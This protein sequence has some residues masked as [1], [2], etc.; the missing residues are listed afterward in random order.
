MSTL[1]L[2]SCFHQERPKSVRCSNC[3]GE[4][5][6]QCKIEELV[7]GNMTAYTNVDA[8]IHKHYEVFC[9]SCYI[10]RVEKRGYGV[11][12]GVNRYGNF[13]RQRADKKP[14]FLNPFGFNGKG[15]LFGYFVLIALSVFLLVRFQDIGIPSFLFVNAITLLIYSLDFYGVRK[16]FN[17]FLEKNQHAN[18]LIE[19]HKSMKTA[20]PIPPPPPPPSPITPS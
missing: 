14:H 19:Q 18:S 16:S 11:P 8:E 15:Q 3:G 12:L 2:R 10:E 4:L 20:F 1:S 9:P 13:K 7:G 17:K 5:C 6:Y